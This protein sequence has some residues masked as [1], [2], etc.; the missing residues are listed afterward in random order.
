MSQAKTPTKTSFLAL[1]IEAAPFMLFYKSEKAIVKIYARKET[2]NAP[3]A[4]KVMVC[5]FTTKKITLLPG[6]N[7]EVLC[8]TLVQSFKAGTSEVSAL[9]ADIRETVALA[10][11]YDSCGFAQQ[12]HTKDTD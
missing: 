7:P 6:A 12:F 9:R 1:D 8:E 2:A 5:G 4:V 3:P 10:S 11:L